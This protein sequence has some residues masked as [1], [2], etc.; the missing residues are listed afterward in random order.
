MVSFA[1][2]EMPVQF[3]GL[4]QEHTAVRER[5]G[6]FDI[7]HMGVLQLEGPNPKDT[8]QQLGLEDGQEILVLPQ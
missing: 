8:L 7:S 1:G 6:M 4:I 2:W 3:T 5:M